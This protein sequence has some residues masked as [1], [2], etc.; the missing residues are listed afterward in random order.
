MASREDDETFD[1]RGVGTAA[2]ALLAALVLLAMV[3]LVAIS[4]RS[5]D[6]AV[7]SERHAYDV[8]LL[9]RTMDASIA[10]AE[11]A[12]G[13]AAEERSPGTE[14][15]LADAAVEAEA[16]PELRID[17]D[18][19]AW[20]QGFSRHT[21]AAEL[22]VG[23]LVFAFRPHQDHFVSPAADVV[24]LP[25]VDPRANTGSGRAGH[26]GVR[27]APDVVRAPVRVAVDDAGLPFGETVSAV[28]VP[29]YSRAR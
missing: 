13:V 20:L 26:R 17:D 2:G 7:A 16:A 10:R 3:F 24:P 25:A 28:T 1:W 6:E 5:S 23:D 8:T 18:V 9:T 29:P 11:A 4:S 15:R 21:L 27:L 22:S 19:V 12:V 14:V